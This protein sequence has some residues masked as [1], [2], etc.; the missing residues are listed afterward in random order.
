MPAKS[1][2]QEYVRE[3][4]P[5]D[6]LK[7]V[8]KDSRASL[9]ELGRSLNISYHNI[10]STLEELGSRYKLEYTLEIDEKALGFAEGRLITIKFEKSPSI[11]FLKE[12]LAKDIFVQDAYLGEGD[13]NL[14]LYVV[15]TTAKEIKSEIWKLRTDFAEYKPIFKSAT[16]D[17]NAIGF[18]P[19][20]SELINESPML[21]N[22][23]KKV[24]MLLNDNSRI[25]LKDICIKC[26]IKNPMHVV[27]IIR[28]LKEKGIIR[29]F[30]ALT[31]N[32]DKR[33]FAASSVS[34]IPTKEHGKFF[35][36]FA[37]AIISEDTKE[38]TNDYCFIADTIGA[39]DGFY[40]CTFTDGEQMAKRGPDLLQLLWAA[41]NPQIEKTVLTYRITGKWPFHLEEYTNYKA[42]VEKNASKT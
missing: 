35:L 18:L 2:T 7:A 17:E 15:A 42:L 6:I 20:K 31:Q 4:L 38:I 5:Y 32:P 24:L 37:R 28:K 33:V 12:R 22:S 41:E 34:L 8:Y 26:R 23:E 16:L 40:I 36:N 21:S 1:E 10:A 11:D 3:G 9:R 19:L 13:F 25:R 29:K 14:L 27:Y 39:Y 30:T